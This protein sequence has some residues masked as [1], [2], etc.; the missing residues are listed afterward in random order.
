[1]PPLKRKAPLSTRHTAPL[2]PPPSV[3]TM[4]LWAMDEGGIIA[5][6]MQSYHAIIA[7]DAQSPDYVAAK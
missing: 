4:R 5:W 2:T 7:L 3:A 1:V 6:S